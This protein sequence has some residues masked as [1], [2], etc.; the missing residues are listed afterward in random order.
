MGAEAACRPGVDGQC[1]GTGGMIN[2]NQ[3]AR[4]NFLLSPPLLFVVTSL[5][6]LVHQINAPFVSMFHGG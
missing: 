5:S 1:L 3:R 4:N 6:C 2:C